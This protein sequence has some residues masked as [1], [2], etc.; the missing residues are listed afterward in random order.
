M[1]EANKEILNEL[2]IADFD[3]ISFTFTDGLLPPAS[4]AAPPTAATAGPSH[5][6]G[7]SV[8]TGLS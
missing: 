1:P 5:A 8:V 3:L 6:A 2:V 7:T 4:A